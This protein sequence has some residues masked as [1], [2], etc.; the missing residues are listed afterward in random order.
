MT[1]AHGVN[2]IDNSYSVKIYLLLIVFLCNMGSSGNEHWWNVVLPSPSIVWANRMVLLITKITDNPEK[3][4]SLWDAFCIFIW[5][6]YLMGF[7]K[8]SS[9]SEKQ[10]SIF[11]S[12]H[13]LH[14]YLHEDHFLPLHLSL[15][16][17]T[18]LE[19][20]GPQIKSV[21]FTYALNYLDLSQR[22]TLLCEWV[23]N[24]YIKKGDSNH[25]PCKSLICILK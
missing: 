2:R 4:I 14:L 7:F 21:V 3:W 19:D 10:F 23:G 1:Y 24:L 5:M 16:K 11:L 13:H 12:L 6:S 15:P 17:C 22:W 9:V 20:T 25:Q 18:F 8:S